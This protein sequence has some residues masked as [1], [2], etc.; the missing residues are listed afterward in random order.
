L[1]S[2]AI[3]SS[4]AIEFDVPAARILVFDT[5]DEAAEAVLDG[6]VAAYASVARA[7]SGFIEQGDNLP[8]EVVTVGTD[9]KEPAVGCFGFSKS[10][11][12]FMRMV[13]QA[14]AAH[15]GS[16]EHRSMMRRFGFTDGEID[17]FAPSVK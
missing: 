6:G 8:L 11:S 9:E 14:L 7:H 1:P 5:Y 17:L 15:L 2:F 4:T 12:A 3:R 16:G 10:D 13:D